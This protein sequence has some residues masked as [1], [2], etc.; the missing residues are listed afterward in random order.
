MKYTTSY[1]DEVVWYGCKGVWPNEICKEPGSD[2][3][4]D[5]TYA[6]FPEELNRIFNSTA[7]ED[8]EKRA[9]DMRR[10]ID[11]YCRTRR[12]THQAKRTFD[13]AEARMLAE[14]LPVVHEPMAFRVPFIG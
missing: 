5:F 11:V 10:V 9:V 14:N 3:H 12:I 13:S 4:V 7:P 2:V 1:L 6:E 8:V